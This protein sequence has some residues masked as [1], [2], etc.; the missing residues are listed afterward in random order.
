VALDVRVL[1]NGNPQVHTHGWT[2][3]STVGL[4]DALAAFPAGSLRHVLCTDIARDGTLGGPN[5][6]LYRDAVG[7]FPGLS[8]QA[9]GG[10][11]CVADLKSLARLGVKAA[12]SGTALLEELIPVKELRPFLPAALSLA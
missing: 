11:R 9:S 1:P 3:N 7:G 6:S 2:C 5:L 12:V 8:W 10:I 4:W